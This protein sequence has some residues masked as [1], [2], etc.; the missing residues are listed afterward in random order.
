MHD[1][2]K[3]KSDAHELDWN[4][5]YAALVS[6]GDEY[7]HCNIPFTDSYECIIQ[8]NTANGGTSGYHYIG[9]LGKWLQNQRQ[10][11]MGVSSI[12][13]RPDRQALLEQL[14]QSEKLSW[15]AFYYKV[16]SRN[17][18][19]INTNSNSNN[20]R[21][22]GGS[23]GGGI[24]IDSSVSS[25]DDN[26]ARVTVKNNNE[27]GNEDGID[28]NHDDK[29]NSSGLLSSIG[30]TNFKA[31][32]PLSYVESKSSLLLQSLNQKLKTSGHT[33]MELKKMRITLC[34][35]PHGR[36]VYKFMCF[37]MHTYIIIFFI[38]IIL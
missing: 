3:N 32:A 21:K 8:E 2:A 5:N 28:F 15:D 23:G 30:L 33:Q 4:R 34:P 29:N 12:K 35:I 11:K 20:H 13:L 1:G 7:G 17:V 31:G 9:Y 19:L 16:H 37:C 26:D 36:F 38:Y 10:A 22:T 18:A 25:D 6:Y 14:V 24:D 27:E